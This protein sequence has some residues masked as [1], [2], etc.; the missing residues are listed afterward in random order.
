[1][2]DFNRFN[3][4]QK[5]YSVLNFFTAEKED[6]TS[7]MF[8]LFDNLEFIFEQDMKKR[9]KLEEMYF[10]LEKYIAEAKELIMQES[11]IYL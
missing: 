8:N 7:K 3:H 6:K 9:D 2:K 5:I 1:M 10:E 4:L 11:K